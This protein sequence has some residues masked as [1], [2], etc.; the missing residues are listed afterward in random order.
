M[1]PRD[2]GG[3]ISLPEFPPKDYPSRPLAEQNVVAAKQPRAQGDPEPALELILGVRTLKPGVVQSDQVEVTY[4][5]G[6]RRFV[7]RYPVQI[8]LCAPFA[9]YPPGCLGPGS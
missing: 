1:L 2:G 3:I 6:N 9:A 8:L 4:L 5:V 7:E